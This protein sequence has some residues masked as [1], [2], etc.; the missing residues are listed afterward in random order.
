MFLAWTI[1]ILIGLRSW[2]SQTSMSLQVIPPSMDHNAS[3]GRTRSPEAGSAGQLPDE[4]KSV[5]SDQQ[6][7]EDGEMPAD[8]HQVTEQKPFDPNLAGVEEMKAAGL[9]GKVAY[10]IK[11]YR[12]KGGRF[13]RKTDLLKIYDMTDSIFARVEPFIVLP[14]EP[15]LTERRASRVMI[16]INEADQEEWT[17]LPGIGKGYAR[18]IC[19]FREALGGFASVQQVG[20]TF[21]LPDSTFQRILPHLQPGAFQPGV[22]INEWDAAQLAGHPYIGPKEARILVNFR[23]QHGAY[24]SAKDIRRALIMIDTLLLNRI[25]PYMNYQSEGN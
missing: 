19:R 12:E 9:P 24:H 8:R 5:S 2:W 16:D 20:E 6:D 7:Q 4:T 10:T 14:E 23:S 1:V 3:L 18:R 17:Y 11:R 15:D 21:G 13:Y 22:R 25:L